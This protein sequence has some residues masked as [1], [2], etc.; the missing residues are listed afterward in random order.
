MYVS[1]DLEQIKD[2]VGTR[3]QGQAKQFGL[4][5]SSRRE[6]G[7][8]HPYHFVKG[9]PI[10]SRYTTKPYVS[11]FNHTPSDYYS[12]TLQFAASE[13]ETQGLELDLAVV[14]WG[15]DLTWNG[16]EWT[17]HFQDRNLNDPKRI[18]LNS[19][20]VLLTRGRDGMIIYIPDIPHLDGT[21]S[22]FKVIGV[23]ELR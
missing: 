7:I 23:E 18:R 13:F 12:S 20:R 10:A 4:V 21:W 17:D 8:Q 16:R 19:Y 3:Y 9:L 15:Y 5:T 6:Y 2:F 1:R 14:C 11:Y 22:L